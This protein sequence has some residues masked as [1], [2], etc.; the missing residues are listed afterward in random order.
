MI[1]TQMDKCEID[2]LMCRECLWE[3]CLRVMQY[4]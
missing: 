1:S 2:E 3:D 4:I